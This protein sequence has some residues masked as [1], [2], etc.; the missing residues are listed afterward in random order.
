M[1]MPGGLTLTVDAVK[2]LRLQMQLLGVPPFVLM[3]DYRA[4]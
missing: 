2:Y 1:E 3:K 4:T